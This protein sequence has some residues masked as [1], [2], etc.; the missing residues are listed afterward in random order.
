MARRTSKEEALR[1]GLRFL[2]RI[3]VRAAAAAAKSGLGDVGEA[4]IEFGER[5]Q[6]VAKKIAEAF[7]GEDRE[8]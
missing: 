4:A 1:E 5:A 2:G 8:D 6:R 3:G 7:P